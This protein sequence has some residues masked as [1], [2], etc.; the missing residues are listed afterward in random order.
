MSLKNK[1]DIMLQHNIAKSLIN[2]RTSTKISDKENLS[3]ESSFVY[4][5][6]IRKKSYEK[7]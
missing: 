1:C 3:N 7:N 5:L 6:L 4:P 2:G